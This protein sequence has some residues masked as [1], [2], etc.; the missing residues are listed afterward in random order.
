MDALPLIRSQPMQAAR[1]D[2][3]EIRGQELGKFSNSK[4]ASCSEPSGRDSGAN[5]KLVHHDWAASLVQHLKLA[6]GCWPLASGSTIGPLEPLFASRAQLSGWLHHRSRQTRHSGRVNHSRP[7][8]PPIMRPM[9]KDSRE[10]CK[11]GC[12]R[13]IKFKCSG[14]STQICTI[15]K[16][17]TTTN[18]CHK[19]FLVRI[20]ERLP[21]LT[22]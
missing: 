5:M 12:Q 13:D 15:P 4:T 7:L 14:S 11:P 20:L 1:D 9:Q 17:T 10:V 19:H 6:A 22:N 8:W 21:H 18:I 16:G 2:Q 3:F